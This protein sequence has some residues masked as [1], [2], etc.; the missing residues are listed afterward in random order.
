MKTTIPHAQ[1]SAAIDGYQKS[2]NKTK[3]FKIN[4]C[5]Q[6]YILTTPFMLYAPK[7]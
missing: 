5:T 4:E 2:K 1:Q 3:L 6:K 7:N